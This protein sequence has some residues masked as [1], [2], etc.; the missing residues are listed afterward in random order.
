MEKGFDI[1]VLLHGDGQYAPEILSHL[2]QPIV[3]GEARGGVRLAHDE[4]LRRAVKG[5]HAFVQV[6]GQ[7]HSDGFRKPALG[8]HL[9]EFHS[10]YR[11]YRLAR[12]GASV[13]TH[14]TDDFHFD[15]EIIIKLHHRKFTIKEVPIPT[16][17]GTESAM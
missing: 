12:A 4:D 7:S 8:L 9:T 14:M 3:T 15:T 16:Y 10:G 13:S 6:S 11:A 1:V 5:R 17:Y 2:Y